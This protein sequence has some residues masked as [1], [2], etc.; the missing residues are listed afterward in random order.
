[1][2]HGAPA[3]GQL[4]GNHLGIMQVS[5]VS[6]WA[7]ANRKGDSAGRQSLLWAVASLISGK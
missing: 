2:D 3:A 5:S 7:G 4:W 6:V 1:M